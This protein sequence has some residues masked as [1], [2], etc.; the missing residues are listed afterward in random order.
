MANNC[1]LEIELTFADSEGAKAFQEFFEGELKKANRNRKGV[2]IGSRRYL[3]DA[4]IDAAVGEKLLINGWVK[5]ALSQDEAVKFIDFINECREL[6]EAVISYEETGEL[7][8]GK[9]IYK[10]FILRDNFI[11]ANHKIW[12]KA[13]VEDDDDDYRA[14]LAK[15]LET[16]GVTQTIN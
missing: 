16:G 12:D 14:E 5:W 11:P 15:A 10:D 9:F 1:I 3:F 8:Y 7:I 13:R 6:K 2:Y 4:E